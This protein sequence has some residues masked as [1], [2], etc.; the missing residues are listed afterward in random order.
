MNKSKYRGILNKI[1]N[2]VFLYIMSACAHFP[3]DADYSG[4]QTIPDHIKSEY[5]YTRYNGESTTDS[6][7]DRGRYIFKKVTINSD[8]HTIMGGKIKLEYYNV[9][10]AGK[11]PV[12]IVLPVLEGAGSI[13]KDFA[14]FYAKNGYSSIIVNRKKKYIK[15]ND[16]IQIN[17]ILKEIVINHRQVID[18]IETQNDLDRERIGVFGISMGGIKS[19]L[20]SQIDNRVN[21]SVIALGGG[22]LPYIL[23][24]SNENSVKRK[25]NQYI[26]ENNVTREEFHFTLNHLISCDP[27]NYA[28]YIDARKTLMI[29]ALFDRCVPFNKGN[30]L[31]SKIGKPETVYLFSGHYT[32]IFYKFYVKRTTLN[33]FKKRF[34]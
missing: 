33:F 10:G 34:D 28:S 3:T 9:K 8:N 32:S 24:Y 17:E 25:R 13:I 6:I 18:W 23:S 30:E 7:E 4:P 11:K 27:I 26:K 31:R 14:E 15:G 1:L 16:F 20:I 29:L 5:S 2:F 12:I 19:A 22:D 21:A